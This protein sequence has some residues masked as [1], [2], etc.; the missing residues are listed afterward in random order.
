MGTYF[1]GVGKLGV[2]PEKQVEGAAKLGV[3]RQDDGRWQLTIFMP[4]RNISIVPHAEI[5]LDA[6][7]AE[8][9]RSFLG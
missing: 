1:N 5:T 8:K 2:M 7:E 4:E 3:V 6:V 9:L